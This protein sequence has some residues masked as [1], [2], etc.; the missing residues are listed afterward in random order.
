VVCHERGDG[1]DGELDPLMHRVAV[2][3]ANATNEG[4]VTGIFG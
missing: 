2:A 4:V 1:R 3:D